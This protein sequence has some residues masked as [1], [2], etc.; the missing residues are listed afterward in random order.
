MSKGL[1]PALSGSIAQSERLDTVANNLANADTNGFKRDQVAFKAVMASATSAAQKEDIPRRAYTE[2][3]FHKLDGAQSA[4]AVVEGTYTD[5]AQGRAKLTGNP[6]DV[7]LEG[8]GFLEVLGPQG[9]RYTRHG[10]LKLSSEGMLVTTEGF[11]VLSPGA[12]QDAN[13]AP[14]SREDLMAR[15]IRFDM[16]KPGGGRLTI[17]TDGK[18]FQ[19]KTELS[20]LSINEFVDPKLLHKEGSSL[21]RNELAA[22]LSQE[23]GGTQVRQGMIETSNVN[24]VAEMV[25]LLKASRLFEANEKIIR[26]YGDMESRAV[27]DLGK[28]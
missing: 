10:S 3:D 20:R 18:I 12:G 4:Y 2:K 23:A 14:V 6:L 15:A 13:G 16:S 7:A 11:P 9:V 19:D 24:T 1:W 26:T 5:F 28:L 25:E 17:T 21:F 22:N 27:N 8:K